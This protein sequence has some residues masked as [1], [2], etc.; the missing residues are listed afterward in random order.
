MGKLI[1]LHTLVIFSCDQSAKAV[2]ILTTSFM[3]WIQENKTT[4]G[5]SEG[6]LWI[7]QI[8]CLKGLCCMELVVSAMKG[9]V[10]LTLPKH[11]LFCL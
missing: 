2:F 3:M 10:N 6:I 8:T 11:W 9:G 4:T 7:A 5:F 1:T